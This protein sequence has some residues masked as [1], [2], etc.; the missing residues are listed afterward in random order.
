MFLIIFAII[1]KVHW[2]VVPRSQHLLRRDAI[3]QGRSETSEAQ[4]RGWAPGLCTRCTGQSRL[5]TSGRVPP[6][7][8]IQPPMTTRG[9]MGRRGSGMPRAEPQ[10]H[11]NKDH[12][13]KDGS[14]RPGT[15]RAYFENFL[16]KSS[17][18]GAPKFMEP[19]PCHAWHH[20][21]ETRLEGR[22]T[23][24]IRTPL[25]SATFEFYYA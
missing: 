14:S 6:T 19:L 13:G 4:Q 24:N 16:H 2:L 10:G 5:F 25:Q 9:L 22:N 1:I 23:G 21:S 12:D 7:N 18:S 11:E 8:S 3:G 15:L 17:I 20:R